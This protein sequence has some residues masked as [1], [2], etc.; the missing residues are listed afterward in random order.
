MPRLL[1]PEPMAMHPCG[2]GLRGSGFFIFKILY[3]ALA[4]PWPRQA[5]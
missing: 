5:G 2:A 3:P 4:W 1:Y